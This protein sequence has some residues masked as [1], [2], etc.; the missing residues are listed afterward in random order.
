MDNSLDPIHYEHLHGVYGNYVAQKL[1]QPPRM[2]PARHLKIDFD[3]FEYGIY[4]RRLMEGAPE[5]C[6]DWTRG[7]PILFPHILLVGDSDA[8]SYQIRVPVD[9]SHTMH[10]NYNCWP[11]KEGAERLWEGIPL[12]R[13]TLFEPDGSI[14]ANTIVKQDML[15]WVGQGPISDRTREHLA[16]SDKGVILYHNMLT[17]QMDV[18]ERGDDPIGVVRDRAKNEPYIPVRWE[19]RAKEV[20]WPDGRTRERSAAMATAG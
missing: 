17:Q 14:I 12:E 6:D 7:H 9:D 8:V 11:V 20:Y 1:G 16:T 5:D 18:V 15:G 13:K 2:N 10:Y 19:D 4:K 3:T